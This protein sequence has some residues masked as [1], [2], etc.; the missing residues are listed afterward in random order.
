MSEC[1]EA[2]TT[3]RIHPR[4]LL[5]NLKQIKFRVNCLAN[6]CDLAIGIWLSCQSDSSQQHFFCSQI[7]IPTICY[8][9]FFE[10]ALL[11]NS[12]SNTLG[13]SAKNTSLEDDCYAVTLPFQPKTFTCLCI[14]AT[15][16]YC[17]YTLEYHLCLQPV[18]YG[19]GPALLV[20]NLSLTCSNIP[21]LAAMNKEQAHPK[22]CITAAP[23][24]AFH[25]G[26]HLSVLLLL[27]P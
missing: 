17:L 21:W 11:I 14:Q 12:T 8:K 6:P 27:T 20:E 2:C 15:F 26:A 3:F 18:P 9:V 13:V 7:P 23:S 19:D 22:I 4:L 5:L 16:H 1:K 10:L 24:R 25:K